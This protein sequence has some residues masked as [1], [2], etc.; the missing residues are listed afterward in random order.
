MIPLVILTNIEFID[1]N[2]QK[3]QVLEKESGITGKLYHFPK[4]SLG[5]RKKD[6]K[7]NLVFPNQILRKQYL[8]LCDYRDIDRIFFFFFFRNLV[9]SQISKE[10]QNNGIF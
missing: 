3:N 4:D 2:K 5:L 7:S 8:R 9:T 1:L 10:S 6:N